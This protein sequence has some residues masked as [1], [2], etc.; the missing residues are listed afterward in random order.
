MKRFLKSALVALMTAS[1]F[2][3][4]GSSSDDPDPVPVPPGPVEDTVAD[5]TFNPAAGEL[6]AD[7]TT[8]ALSTATADA[9]IYYQI[10]TEESTVTLSKDNY[11]GEGISAYDPANK[12]A[13]TGPATIYAIAV[14]DDKTSN[15]TSAAYTIAAPETIPADSIRTYGKDVE[16]GQ[17][18]SRTAFKVYNFKDLK[19]LA[20]LVNGGNT[21]AGVTITQAENIVINENLLSADFEAPAEAE[22]G[23]PN[24]NFVVFDG[25]GQIEKPFAGT[26]DGAQ[27]YVSGAY[28]YGGHQGLGF[29]GATNGAT[30]EGL[31]IIDS[32]V[33]NKNT[34][35]DE[36]K[37]NTPAD[38]GTDDDRFG[39]I[40]GLV[41]G[42]T[43]INGCAF[44]GTV[45]SAEAKA[46]GGAYQYIGGVVGRVASGT[47]TMEGVSAFANL[48]A[49]SDAKPL[50]GKYGTV[51]DSDCSGLDLDGN[52]YE[53]VKGE[54]APFSIIYKESIAEIMGEA[55]EGLEPV[56]NAVMA[57]VN[58]AKFTLI[59]I[60]LS[61][62]I[63]E[64]GITADT[65]AVATGYKVTLSYDS[66]TLEIDADDQGIMWAEAAITF[67]TGANGVTFVDGEDA[68]LVTE[69]PDFEA[70]DGEDDV[71]SVYL[72]LGVEDLS[73][74]F[75]KEGYKDTV[76]K[77]VFE[78]APAEVIPVD[79]IRMYEEG[80]TAYSVYNYK[81]LKKLASLVNGGN[82]LTGVTITQ[83][84]DIVVNDSV[85]GTAWTA[86]VEVAAGEA[87]ADLEVFDGIGNK[88]NG[89]AGTY[90]GD[91]YTISGVY[92][93]GAH[94][95]LGFFGRTDGA[96]L[97]N[98]VLLDSCTVAAAVDGS[99]DDRFG[100]LI[101]DVKTATTIKDCVFVGTVGSAEAMARD[102]T[103]E[104]VGGL[105]GRAEAAGSTA[106]GCLVVARLYAEGNS[107]SNR[108]IVGYKA[109]P[110][111]GQWTFTD[112]VGYEITSD[113]DYTAE[114]AEAVETK[115]AAL[116]AARQ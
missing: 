22:A 4:C 82:N 90:N 84:A 76:V 74:T 37:T 53:S 47:L 7:D 43:T 97:K 71:Y 86:P 54:K 72:P 17:V 39:G 91:G 30:I 2:M 59:D 24:A 94:Q 18:E 70:V 40:V 85:L 78:D 106:S 55:P 98:I 103:L 58:K 29:F 81:D 88:E 79:S 109:A 9:V 80:G 20:D 42:D 52:F 1:L 51:T 110:D 108:P 11:S 93:Y 65:E 60:P 21:L 67:L 12:P 105:A 83:K 69:S 44:V 89:F 100:G 25:I 66:S 49:S 48:Y 63:E 13:L 68:V 41:E 73:Y 10:V 16:E 102:T 113:S 75:K 116:V 31:Y 36:A 23:V 107:N 99:S 77:L 15:V 57:F 19:K 56:A 26:Y 35:C 87:N 28:V 115:I 64:E 14:K 104:Y 45:G 101:G 111:D 50:V 27:H 61:F 92:I 46:R 95:Y 5:V 114:I 6:D 34:A 96:T 62:A 8:V 32:C 112:C 33:V 38:D 3:A